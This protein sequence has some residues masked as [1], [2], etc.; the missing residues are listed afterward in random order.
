MGDKMKSVLICIL[1]F[2]FI[3]LT[4]GQSKI[5]F[6]GIPKTKISEAGTSRSIDNIDQT[7]SS[8]FRC[9]IHKN[10]EKYYWVSRENKEMVKVNSNAFDTYI[11]L[12]GSGFV[13]IIKKGM[14]ETVS[15]MG[16]TETE[17]DY[18]EHLLLGLKSVTYYGTSE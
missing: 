3:N 4:F 1:P 15:L 9:V 2:L 7:T 17:F 13:R 14:K 12:D 10:G 6:V 16:E 5:E 8:K 18:V 11:S